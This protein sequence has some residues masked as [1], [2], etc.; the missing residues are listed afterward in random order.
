MDGALAPIVPDQPV[1]VLELEQLR[2]LIDTC[3]DIPSSPGATLIDWFY[4]SVRS[5]LRSDRMSHRGR[6]AA[7]YRQR[8]TR[9]NYSHE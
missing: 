5:D 1:P 4:T 3:R 8:G 7:T 2:A 9:Q 6:L